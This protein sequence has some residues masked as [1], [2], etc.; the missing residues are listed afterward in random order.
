MELEMGI[1]VDQVVEDRL[2][3]LQVF[4]AWAV[5]AL[6]DKDLLGVQ[7]LQ[8]LEI[9]L[10]VEVVVLPQ[11][12]LRLLVMQLGLAVLG[13]L[14]LLQGQLM[15]VG[16]VVELIKERMGLVALVVADVVAVRVLH[17]MAPM[18]QQILVAE[19]EAV[20]VPHQV[21]L[22]MVVRALFC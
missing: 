8:D 21:W 22:V 9:V 5:V 7:V 15:Q 6:L 14:V 3:G 11:L 13:I 10:V 2:R 18:A 16:A 4:K 12:A 20:L 17:L 19:V 1:Q